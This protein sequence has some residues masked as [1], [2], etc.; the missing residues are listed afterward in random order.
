MPYNTT[1]ESLIWLSKI[2]ITFLIIYFTTIL[3]FYILK[4]KLTKIINN[5]MFVEI[6]PFEVIKEVEVIKEI[7]VIKEVIKEVYVDDYVKKFIT[8]FEEINKLDKKKS[9]IITNLDKKIIL[10]QEVNIIH[11][12][13]NPFNDKCINIIE[14]NILNIMN[15]MIKYYYNNKINNEK[16]NINKEILAFVKK[17]N[18]FDSNELKEFYTKYKNILDK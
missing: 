10:N 3:I 18:F 5:E 11:S 13:I 7:E 16:N 6:I 1:D 12:K 14:L 15:F 17:V 8:D 4:K 9:N 2:L